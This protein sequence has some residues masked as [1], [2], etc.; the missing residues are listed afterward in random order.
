MLSQRRWTSCTSSGLR[1][2]R[3]R[4]DVE[5]LDVALGADDIEVELALGLGQSLPGLAHMEGLIL[6]GD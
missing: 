1:D 5:D 4:T 2:G 3:V 6:G